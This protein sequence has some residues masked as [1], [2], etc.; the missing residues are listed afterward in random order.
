[1]TTPLEPI[2]ARVEPAAPARRVERSQRDA[3]RQGG[4]QH[5]QP[6]R[7]APEHDGDEPDGLHVDVRA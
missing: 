2:R 1:V 5:R 7:R 4:G 6:D 3:E